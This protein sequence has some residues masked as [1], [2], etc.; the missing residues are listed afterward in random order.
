MTSGVH[1]LAFS[2]E[3]QRWTV[4]ARALRPLLTPAFPL[5]LAPDDS[6]LRCERAN[7]R[8]RAALSVP[9][10][11]LTHARTR[12]RGALGRPP[13]TILLVAQ[14]GDTRGPTASQQTRIEQRMHTALMY[15]DD[16][17]L[18]AVGIDR[19]VALVHAWHK[20]TSS[21]GLT[22]VIPEQRQAGSSVLWLGVVF[23]AAAG[24]LFLLRDKDVRAVERIQRTL[25]HSTDTAALRKLCGLLQHVRG[26]L[27]GPPSWMHGLYRGVNGRSRG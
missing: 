16:V 22:M 24:V 23:V 25:A 12:R 14:S 9:T 5:T 6:L 15:T 3:A 18:A 1:D 21:V 17:V 26:V 2:E 27:V 10:R 4:G 13:P 19:I 20:V 11:Q 8:F 7:A